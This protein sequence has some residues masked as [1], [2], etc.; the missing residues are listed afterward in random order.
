MRPLFISLFLH[1]TTTRCRNNLQ[2]LRC[3][4][5]FFYI[6]P[7]LMNYSLKID[8]VVYQSFS[9]SNHNFPD[10]QAFADLL[11][12]SL[13]LHQTTTPP[14]QWCTARSLFISL[15]LHQ[16]T[17]FAPSTSL[18]LSVVY[19]SFSTSNHNRYLCQPQERML[20]ISLFLHQTTTFRHTL[21]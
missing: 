2:G 11:F 15:F 4:S 14:T 7:Q 8:L 16:T 13:F 21:N 9:T 3:L 6:K 20:F 1:Q 18:A 17:T 10:F 5:V 12:I 19:Q